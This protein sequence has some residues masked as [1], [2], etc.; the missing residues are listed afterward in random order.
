MIPSANQIAGLSAAL[1]DDIDTKLRLATGRRSGEELGEHLYG[2]K[3]QLLA[4]YL[5]LERIEPERSNGGDA[6]SW[7]VR[8]RLN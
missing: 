8:M 3:A 2:A 6:T 7:R 4:G 1:R 5:I